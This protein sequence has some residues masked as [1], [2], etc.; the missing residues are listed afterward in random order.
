MQIGIKL[1]KSREAKR[2]SQ[3]EVAYMIGV[4][5]S[6]YFTWE[7]GEQVNI[8]MKYVAKIVEVLG[9]E[10]SELIPKSA[11]L[12]IEDDPAYDSSIKEQINFTSNAHLFFEEMTATYRK[13]VALLEE[14]VYSQNQIIHQLESELNIIRKT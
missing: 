8:R 9:L 10:L 4:S 3:S 11:T 6:T 12:K 1:R 13:M 2:L 5:Q 14:K 7:S